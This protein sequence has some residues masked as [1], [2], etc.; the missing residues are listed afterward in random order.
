MNFPLRY[1]LKEAFSSFGRGGAMGLVAVLALTL[2]SMSGGAYL[3]LRQNSMYWFSQAEQRF[4]AVVYFKDGM[5]DASA[6]ALGEKLKALP[7]VKDLALLS[8][9]DAAKELAK[10]QSL[11]DYF[12][13]LANDNPLPWAAH[14][15]MDSADEVVLSG[16]EAAAR[17][18][19][20][21][22]EVDWG[23]DSAEALLKWMKLLRLSLLLLGL[24]LAVSAA[25]VT[26]S[27]I[28]LTVHVR[29][30][31][32][33]IMRMVGAGHWFIRVPLLLEGTL[34]GALGG[35]LG[36]L[37]LALLGHAV[38]HKALNDLKMDLS[39]YLP[40]GVTPA[41]GLLLVSASSCLGFL[42]SFLAVGGSVREQR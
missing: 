20:G 36:C 15:H 17:Q 9:A 40:F 30:E 16:F 5:D 32:I 25:L 29:R 23:R 3:L 21:V 42:G 33:S 22:S 11:K 7:E 13:V 18:M 2:A 37:L 4:E 26:A 28:R 6:K 8:P 19:D 38:D 34:Q 35:G 27:V 31:E 1:F 10:D 24:A 41:F 12:Q 14:V 39:A